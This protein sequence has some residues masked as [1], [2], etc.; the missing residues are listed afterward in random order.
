MR[1]EEDNSHK[2][3]IRALHQKAKGRYGYQRLLERFPLGESPEVF[4]RTELVAE[5]LLGQLF[6]VA[7]EEAEMKVLEDGSERFSFDFHGFP[8]FRRS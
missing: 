5:R 7:H 6:V 3:R 2:E 4:D 1:A 8:W